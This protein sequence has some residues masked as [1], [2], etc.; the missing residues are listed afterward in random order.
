MSIDE[1]LRST[2]AMMRDPRG[3][4]VAEA[5]GRKLY[6]VLDGYVTWWVQAATAHGAFDAI[7]K[8]EGFTEA[9]GLD[10]HPPYTYE[11]ARRCQVR[12]D[13]RLVPLI[14]LFTGREDAVLAC[15][16]WDGD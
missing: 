5:N 6:L 14:S 11:E 7:R 16:E 12:V 13:S 8:T 1:E 9:E 3:H 10:A 2:F 15:S 4:E